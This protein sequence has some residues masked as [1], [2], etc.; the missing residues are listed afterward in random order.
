MS[1][2][3]N[4][5]IYASSSDLHK[6]QN[7]AR[8]YASHYVDNVLRHKSDGEISSEIKSNARNMF[9]LQGT[10]N[11]KMVESIARNVAFDAR[12]TRQEFIDPNSGYTEGNYYHVKVK[13][14][15]R[16]KDIPNYY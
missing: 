9:N 3:N 8:K 1:N 2:S 7:L 5:K 13:P 12:V 14:E 11:E 4:E 15:Y 16:N 6:H 10:E